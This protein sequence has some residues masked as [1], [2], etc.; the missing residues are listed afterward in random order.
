MGISSCSH[1]FFLFLFVVIIP[2]QKAHIAEYDVYCKAR[3]LEAIEN[4]DKAY[5]SNPKEVVRHYNDHFSKTML[6]YYITKR[7]LAESKKSPFEVTNHIDSGKDGEFYVVTNPIDNAADPKPGALRHVVTQTGPLWITFK[8]SMTI[9]LQQELIVTSDNT[10]DARGANVKICNG[11]GITI[12]FANNVIIHGLQTHHI[13]P[14]KGG[15]IKDG[16]NH[17]GLRSD[18]DGDRVSLFGATNI[19]LDHLSL[20]HCTNGLIDVVQ[21]ST[22]VTVSNCH[23]TDH[24]DGDHFENGAFFTP[25][26]DP[27]ASKQF[28]ADKMM[29]FKLGEMVL[30]LT[31]YSYSFFLF[32]FVVIIPTLEAHIAEYDEYWK[33]RELEAIENLDTAYHSNPEEVNRKK[34]ADY[35]PGFA[36]GTTGG[37]DGEFYVVTNPIDNAADP[38]PGTLR[39]AV[40]QTR[41]LWITFKGSMTIKLQQELIVTSDKTIDAR[42]ANVEICNGVGITIQFAKNVIIHGLQIHHI[43]PAKGG[44]IKDGENHHWLRGDS[45]GDG[46]SLFGATNV[47]LD[48]LSLHHCA[49]GLIDV[50]QGSTTVRISNCHFTDHNDVMLFGANNS[51]STD[52][53]MQVTNALNHFRKGL[54]KRMPS[55]PTIISQGNR[56]SVPGTFGA[57]GVTC[58]GLLKPAQWKNWNWVSQGDHFENG[59]FFTPSGNP[60]AS[61]QLGADKM[62]PFKPG[63]MVP[64]LTKKKLVDCAPGFARGTTGGKGGEFYVVTDLIDNAVDPKPGTLR[65]AVTQTRPLWISFKGITVQVAKNV[66]I[67]D[68]QIR[69][70]IPAKGGMIKDGENHNGLWGARDRDGVSLFGAI[71]FPFTIAPMALSMSFKDPQPLPFLTAISLTTTM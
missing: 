37:K 58:S 29:P 4:L 27:S 68:L 44:N 33:A 70:I 21:G 47:W 26:G 9:K 43:I 30:E 71:I 65:H 22:A 59:A 53:K 57:K 3:G 66:I 61:K 24:N 31:N 23:F 45:D 12:Q 8:G 35:A 69:N 36:R 64:E 55:N 10:I 15:K 5:Y 40:T 42:G 2:S 56:Y 18:S 62:M 25:F 63:Q 1:S 48:H 14:A 34:L 67:H 60:S 28:G 51:Y 41:P 52:K 16:E 50:V 46:V 7:M 13:I 32:L 20:H 6:E 38:K 39:H 19:W 11:A 17:H 49:D 54:V